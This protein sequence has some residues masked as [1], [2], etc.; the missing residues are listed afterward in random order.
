MSAGR[1][2]LDHVILD[3]CEDP[4]CELHNLDVA[5][6]EQVVNQTEVAYWLAGVAWAFKNYDSF[7]PTPIWNKAIVMA[8][9]AKGEV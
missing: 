2:N 4:D 1:S 7:S 8:G 6:D 5:I 3:E 9:K